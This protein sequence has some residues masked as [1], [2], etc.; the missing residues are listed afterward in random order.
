MAEETMIRLIK[1]IREKIPQSAIA[2]EHRVGELTIGDRAVVIA[3]SA[4]HRHEA[5]QACREMIDRLKECVPIWKK[6]FYSDG[7][8]WVGLGP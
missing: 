6:E 1:E 4:P 2:V 7:A 5:F 8:I 3:A